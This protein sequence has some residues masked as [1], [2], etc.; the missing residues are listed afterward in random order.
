MLLRT[1]I[2]LLLLV[3]PA[4]AV[5]SLMTMHVE[6][7]SFTYKG[8][9]VL[10]I[11][12]GRIIFDVLFTA[13]NPN[14]AGL[15]NVVCSYDLS[16]EGKKFLSGQ[17]IALSL[18]RRS[19][20][21]V[22]VPATVAFTDLNAAAGVLLRRL[23]AGKKTITLSIDTVFSGRPALLTT[24]EGDKELL[25]ELHQTKTFELPLTR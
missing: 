4:C 1:V 18:A 8:I 5:T 15:R 23:A 24:A 6:P 14:D 3:L 10:A 16:V 13:H 22:R 11:E 2:A 19:D 25:F 17:E 7:P 9:E 20:S 12:K 21:E